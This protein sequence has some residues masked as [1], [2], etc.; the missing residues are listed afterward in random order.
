MTTNV[1]L[2]LQQI[3]ETQTKS[4]TLFNILPQVGNAQSDVAVPKLATTFDL[5]NVTSMSSSP[6]AYNMEL[7][8]KFFLA[9]SRQL[10]R[11]RASAEVVIANNEE[12]INVLREEA[13]IVTE[14]ADTAKHMAGQIQTSVEASLKDSAEH[15]SELKSRKENS[16][17]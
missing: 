4:K 2:T 13:P 5:T 9:Q 14:L 16:V 10:Q 3:Q 7:H 11:L 1:Q 17:A 12:I 15:V 6:Q 8:N